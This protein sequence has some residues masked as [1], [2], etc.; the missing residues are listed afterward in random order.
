MK[1]SFAIVEN[2]DLHIIPDE[3]PAADNLVVVE[4]SERAG[5]HVIRAADAV[6]LRRLLASPEIETV[7]R[8][9]G[10]DAADELDDLLTAISAL[11]ERRTA[12]LRGEDDETV[13]GYGR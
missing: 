10:P 9:V 7:V 1:W 2:G 13:D 5:V 6:E 12:R 3:L 8:H 4:I 11:V